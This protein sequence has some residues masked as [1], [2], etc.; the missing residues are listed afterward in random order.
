MIDGL[1]KVACIRP[2]TTPYFW[3]RGGGGDTTLSPFNIILY[4]PYN[5]DLAP[6]VVGGLPSTTN[7]YFIDTSTPGMMRG[8]PSMSP[9]SKSIMRQEAADLRPSPPSTPPTQCI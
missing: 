9:E 8:A 2:H 1:V 7:A 4:L 5:Y 6:H 3:R